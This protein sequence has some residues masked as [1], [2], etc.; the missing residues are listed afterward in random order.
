MV[1]HG[2]EATERAGRQFSKGAENRE[3]SEY[4]ARAG[5]FTAPTYMVGLV[6]RR[7]GTTLCML[8][9]T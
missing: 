2:D 6:P 9:C 5:R 4:L 3:R 7:L 1:Q 8:K